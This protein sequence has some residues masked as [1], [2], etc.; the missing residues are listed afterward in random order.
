VRIGV[1]HVYTEA[2]SGPYAEWTACSSR[3]AEVMA[4]LCAEL[5]ARMGL[6]EVGRGGWY[7]TFDERNRQRVNKLFGWID[8]PAAAPVG[9]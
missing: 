5:V 6:P 4:E 3:M 8:E 7:S 9:S 1:V 2:A